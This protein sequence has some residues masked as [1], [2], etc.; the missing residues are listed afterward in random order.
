T[1][2]CLDAI[3]LNYYFHYQFGNSKEYSQSDMGWDLD[4]SGIYY[5]LKE[6]IPYNKVVYVTEAGLADEKD[7]YRS[8]YIKRLVFWMHK[9]IDEGV[10]LRGYI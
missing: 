5:V 3:S 2:H 1:K 10:N 7:I 6:L 8:G 9:A 4:P